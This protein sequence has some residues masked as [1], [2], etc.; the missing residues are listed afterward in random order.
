MRSAQTV[1][2]LLLLLA[3]GDVRPSKPQ[4]S[5]EQ[6]AS[7][8]SG[9]RSDPKCQDKGPRGEYLDK[10]LN[11]EYCQW[12]TLIQGDLYGVVGGYKY[13]D[14][15]GYVLWERFVKNEGVVTYVLDSLQKE[16]RAAGFRE[17]KC[18]GGGTLWQGDSIDVQFIR[19]PVQRRNAKF[20]ITASPASYDTVPGCENVPVRLKRSAPRGVKG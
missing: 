11:Q 10:I 2:L 1:A 5:L 9:G 4:P 18:D 20:S 14:A 3:C 12:P 16:F 8:W 13:P 15:Y 6:L 19:G 17:W 7:G